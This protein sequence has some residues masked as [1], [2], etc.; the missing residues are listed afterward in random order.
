MLRGPG[1]PTGNQP[2]PDNLLCKAA[3]E[4][5]LPER[6][7]LGLENIPKGIGAVADDD[8]AIPEGQ[9]ANERNIR[10]LPHPFYVQG[11]W[12]LGLDQIER[13]SK[14]ELIVLLDECHVA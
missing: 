2:V 12:G 9:E 4:V 11:R 6:V 8:L 3:E 1:K 13:L 10:V 7:A 14:E 5:A